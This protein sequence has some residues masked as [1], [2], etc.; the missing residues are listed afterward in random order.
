MLHPQTTL[1]CAGRLLSLSEPVVMG[2]LNIT[3]DSFFAG[4]RLTETEI[5][6]RAEKMLA[7][8]A[9]ILDVGGMSTRPGA[10]VISVEEELQ[11]VN[12]VLEQL[13]R[14]FPEAILSLDTVHA[15]TAREGAARGVGI[16]NDVS[17]GRLDRD[18][19][20]TVAALKLPYVLMHM[21]GRPEN[22]QSQTEYQD[23]T[24]E[25]LDYLIAELGKLRAAGLTDVIVDPGFGFGKT[26]EQNFQ[27]LANLHVLQI[28]DCPILVGLSRKSMI[29]R[30]LN[31]DA[32]G[33]LNGTSVLHLVALQQGAKILRAHDVKEAREVITLWQ[34]L[35]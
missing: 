32:E 8:G 11:R 4:S 23:V 35:E 29:Y 15:R 2:V 31:T 5:L 25:I 24:L 22:M 18:M 21:K 17:A 7:D 34:A 12:P 3:P 9:A 13:Q 14:H 10:S 26:A 28:M 1:N 16:I 20:E 30:T 6:P 33:A 19:Y 27:I